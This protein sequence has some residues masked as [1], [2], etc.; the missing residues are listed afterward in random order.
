MWVTKGSSVS[1]HGPKKNSPHTLAPLFWNY[2]A[3][4]S[5]RR[6]VFVTWDRF[7][8]QCTGSGRRAVAEDHE[9]DGKAC[10]RCSE[11]L[12]ILCDIT[13]AS[14]TVPAWP[15]RDKP[16]REQRNQ[17]GVPS[18][19]FNDDGAGHRFCAA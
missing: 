16:L 8:L 14:D 6:Q 7:S 3:T 13:L 19:G 17:P 5:P 4:T 18:K 15:F 10:F 11:V 9:A 2:E 1:H 12:K